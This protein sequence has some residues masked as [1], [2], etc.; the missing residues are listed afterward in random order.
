MFAQPRS[1]TSFGRLAGL[2]VALVLVPR[3]CLVFVGELASDHRPTTRTLW[4]RHGVAL[5]RSNEGEG[6]GVLP[7]GEKMVKLEV[8]GG[9][10]LE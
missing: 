10:G 9:V 5:M 4:A 3:S 6:F 8:G 7:T 2:P 1:T